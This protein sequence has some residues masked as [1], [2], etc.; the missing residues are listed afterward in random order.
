MKKLLLLGLM[1]LGMGGVLWADGAAYLK[2][3]SPLTLTEAVTASESGTGV[4]IVYNDARLFCNASNGSI[5]D[6]SLVDINNAVCGY[7]FKLVYRT[8][9]NNIRY[10]HIECYN[11]DNTLIAAGTKC[12]AYGNNVLST[13][14]WNSVW[15]STYDE[16]KTVESE[17]IEWDGRGDF[18]YGSQWCFE[19]DGNGGY[20]IKNRG[21]EANPYVTNYGAVRAAEEKASFKFYSLAKKTITGSDPK[22]LNDYVAFSGTPNEAGAYTTGKIGWTFNEGVDMSEYKYLVLNVTRNATDLSQAITITDT[23]NRSIECDWYTKQGGNWQGDDWAAESK[24]AVFKGLW[25]DT[26]N[27]QRIVIID[28]EWLANQKKNG[29]KEGNTAYV[30]TQSVKSVTIDA[31]CAGLYFANA[32]LTNRAP[33]YDGDHNRTSGLA[34]GDYGTV[35]LPYTAVCCGADVYRVTNVT[36]TAVTISPVTGLMEAGQPYVFMVNNEND[37]RFY[38]AGNTMV[39][40]PLA[41]AYM[42]GTFIDSNDVPTGNYILSG[43]QFYEVNSTINFKANRAYLKKS[44][45]P[46]NSRQ[47]SIGFDDETT[48]DINS[49]ETIELNVENGDWYTLSGVKL[50]GKPTKSGIYIMGGKKVIVQ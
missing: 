41:D 2:L 30:N 5:P 20:Y 40:A 6:M 48:T 16:T 47:L 36:T 38:R 44:A 24:P 15:S 34:V 31:N 39:A 28:L 22:L 26:W 1:L 35:C 23:E 9:V 25:F 33:T 18:R 3:G 7:M 42:A 19:S 8:T 46:A 49:V 17:E 12:G 43:D 37:V 11:P 50:N 13:V 4:A 27:N 21:D 32:W 10:Y 14:S 29:A 45:V